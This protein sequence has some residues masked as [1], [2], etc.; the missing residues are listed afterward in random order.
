MAKNLPTDG[1]L[2]EPKTGHWTTAM[3]AWMRD[4]TSQAATTAGI[5]ALTGDVTATGPGSAV[6]TLANTAV[7]PST[8]GDAT[9][10][11]QFTVDH[12][13]RLTAASNVAI[14]GSGSAITALT[15][16]VTATGPGSVAATLST[17]GVSAA[18]Y[19][20]STHVGQFTVDA[21]GRISSAS[22]VAISGG[23]GGGNVT[24]TTTYASPPGSPSSG[25]LDLY[26]DS[27]YIGRYSGSAW[28]PWGPIFPFTDPT[29][30]GPTTWVNQGSATVSTTNGGIVLTAELHSG[31]NLNC[32]VK[33]A[34]STP[35][36]I[37][38]AFLP[39][40]IS[41]TANFGG[42]LFRESSSG[43]LATFHLE[44][45]TNAMNLVA[46]KYTNPTTFSAAYSSRGL[47][48]MSC[49]AF[50][51]IADNGTNRIC[52]YSADFENW[53][54]FF[55]VSRTDFLTADQVGFFCGDSS[56]T[57]TPAVT[58]LSWKET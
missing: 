32:R 37:T 22:N 42:L 33:T 36:V 23:G 9:H 10:V 52:S 2:V 16:D 6:A 8:Y 7:T 47:Y 29:L 11:G 40:F 49:P 54:V 56:N 35:Y 38:A 27:F 45:D 12:K 3:W 17:T 34:P 18:T 58:L 19:G 41:L 53:A 25:D 20:D 5:T 13:G 46:N 15:G 57:Y 39:R 48:T 31:N 1:Q 26:S 4:I 44:A 55:S 30:A 28:V 50:L 14:T 21:K 51:R 43:K 24:S